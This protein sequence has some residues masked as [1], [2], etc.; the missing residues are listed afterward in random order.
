MFGT[1]RYILALM[2]AIAHLA[3]IDMVHVGFYAVFG[4]FTLSGYL[5][6]MVLHNTYFKLSSGFEKYTINR[7]LRVMPAYWVVL[8][9]SAIMAFYYPTIS[10]KIHERM[11]WPA[12][13]GDWLANLTVIGLTILDGRRSMHNLVP[14]AWSLSVEI[15][16]WILM[17]F[18]VR[19]K[20]RLYLWGIAAV[21]YTIYIS[22]IFEY[23]P[24][25]IRYYSHLAAALPFFAGAALYMLTERKPTFSPV[26]GFAFITI[27][28]AYYI[29]SP[30]IFGSPEYSRA[31]WD[32]F[33]I[34]Y[35][36]LYIAMLINCITIYVLSR[37]NLSALPQKLLR[38]DG[39]LGNLA[40]PIFLLHIITAII[41]VS[42]FDNKCT[43]SICGRSWELALAV[44]PLVNILAVALWVGVEKP[45]SIIR[46]RIKRKC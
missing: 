34:L 30:W 8:L 32:D 15:I 16:F 41:L 37:I 42:I 43:M 28:T 7:L 22:T 31:N 25:Q 45:V 2:V 33:Q 27:S 40:Y 24:L 38:I 39:W 23:P 18:L 12:S 13:N 14:P 4:F 5:M 17:P 36:G 10:H 29:V 44:F 9:L 6:T 19:T 26:I 3:P 11:Q 46:E 1:Y 21:G 20:L 35:S